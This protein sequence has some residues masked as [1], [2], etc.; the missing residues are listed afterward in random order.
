ML[1]HF[2]ET[3]F[4]VAEFTVERRA[5]PRIDVQAQAEMTPLAA[6]STRLGG[7]I[8]NVSSHGLR[9]RVA[10]RISGHPRSGDVY[11]ILSGRDL[12]LAEICYCLPEE[13]S[14]DVGFKILHWSNAG[15]LNRIV[16]T[17]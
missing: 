6:V 12:M 4:M 3:G 9:V 15:E 16:Q 10:G 2:R 11:R 7:Q 17:H 1:S 8:T 14:A 13:Q 5:E